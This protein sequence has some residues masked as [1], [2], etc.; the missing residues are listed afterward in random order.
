MPYHTI[1]YHTLPYHTTPDQTRTEQTRPDQNRTDQ[2]SPYHTIPYHTIK[3]HEMLVFEERWKPEYPE[4]NLSEEGES[5]QQTRPTYMTPGPTIEPR[6]HW[7]ETSALTASCAIWS[8]KLITNFKP[9]TFPEPSLLPVAD[10]YR[11]MF[12]EQDWCAFL[13]ILIQYMH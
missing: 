10:Q 11:R 13:M 3:Y 12:S 1:H 9:V 7:W 4:K 8:K 2:T 5:Q 6:P